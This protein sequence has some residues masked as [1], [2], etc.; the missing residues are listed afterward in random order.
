MYNWRSS[1]IYPSMY[2]NCL[3]KCAIIKVSFVLG[4][5]RFQTHPQSYSTKTN[6]SVLL[7]CSYNNYTAISS[8]SWI[9][10]GNVLDTRKLKSSSTTTVQKSGT[11]FFTGSTQFSRSLSFTVE[12]ADQQGFYWCRIQD[13]L[14]RTV[15]SNRSTIKF[16]GK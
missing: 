16:T 3:E 5:A 4:P 9:K 2:E 15:E 12:K 14:S 10:D 6:T 1:H 7:E 13:S 8:F 11:G